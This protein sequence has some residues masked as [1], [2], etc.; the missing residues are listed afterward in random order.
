MDDKLIV[1][2]EAQG[3]SEETASTLTD[4]CYQL[5]RSTGL[6]IYTIAADLLQALDRYAVFQEDDTP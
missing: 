6:G 4:A 5:A 2:W 1:W 3:F